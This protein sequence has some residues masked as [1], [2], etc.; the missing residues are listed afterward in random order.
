MRIIW[1]NPSIKTRIAMSWENNIRNRFEG[2]EFTPS[3]DVWRQVQHKIA[4]PAPKRLAWWSTG[5]YAMAAA[6]ALLLTTATA[7]WVIRQ[8]EKQPVGSPMA[9]A[10]AA[11]GSSG[12]MLPPPAVVPV[13]ASIPAAP[14]SRARFM[15]EGR[16]RIPDPKPADE[17]LE[18][19]QETVA[20]PPRDGISD[21]QLPQQQPIAMLSER[22]NPSVAP[23]AWEGRPLPAFQWLIAPGQS[24]WATNEVLPPP[25]I[26][27]FPSARP[28]RWRMHVSAMPYRMKPFNYTLLAS[29]EK[30]LPDIMP[31]DT[32]LTY[33]LPSMGMAWQ[34]TAEYH[35]AGQWG[36]ELG[37]QV[38][39]SIASAPLGY[40]Y[41]IVLPGEPNNSA[42]M[43]R[44]SDE[45]FA[46]SMT[47][48]IDS[49]V[50]YTY[51]ES[52]TVIRLPVL[53]NL[54]QSFGRHSFSVSAGAA[55]LVNISRVIPMRRIDL[56]AIARV[57]YEYALSPNL[58]LHTGVQFG[59]PPPRGDILTPMHVGV[60]TGVAFRWPS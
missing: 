45:D 12:G 25:H 48:A 7:L 14:E 43:S 21:L 57:R 32:V 4:P 59:A 56:E 19:S 16:P 13:P 36:L 38:A 28:G 39:H 29:N 46:P 55:R 44:N 51:T 17:I 5:R 24:V 52:H 18:E 41:L 3:D 2:A 33:R 47:S 50:T 35:V 49:P 42:S 9:V 60:Q 53:L 58:S 1:I 26:D 15:A 6:V 23:A 27:A 54:Y 37:M 31:Y 34:A 11:E 8:P 40:S 10:P 30:P 20:V 22:A